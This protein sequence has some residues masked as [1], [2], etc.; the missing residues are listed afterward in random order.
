VLP[1][2]LAACDG[3]SRRSEL[4]AW[5]P[6]GIPAERRD[7]VRNHS[8]PSTEFCGYRFDLA[9]RL[10]HLV[11]GRI[12]ESVT[13]RL[14]NPHFAYSACK[15]TVTRTRLDAAAGFTIPSAASNKAVAIVH[16]HLSAN[17]A[18]PAAATCLQQ[19][20]L[21]PD[22][23]RGVRLSSDGVSAARHDGRMT[24]ERRSIK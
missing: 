22:T 7:C 20:S 23:P 24:A 9:N 4:L 19:S 8:R 21:D 18:S 15:I 6:D 3:L 13:A 16:V 1:G 10:S 14:H 5:R 12:V 11:L 17:G 2:Q